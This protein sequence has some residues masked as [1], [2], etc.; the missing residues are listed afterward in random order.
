[1]S[2][3]KTSKRNAILAVL[4]TRGKL[5]A[6][7]ISL[8][9]ALMALP[10]V[11]IGAGLRRRRAWGRP[12]AAALAIAFAALVV[13]SGCY[14]YFR[15]W[16]LQTGPPGAGGGLL[17]FVKVFKTRP[18]DE[19]VLTPAMFRGLDNYLDAGDASREAPERI[20]RALKDKPLLVVRD[21]Q[22]E[23]RMGEPV[24]LVYSPRWNTFRGETSLELLAHDFRVGAV[25]DL[26]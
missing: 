4:E 11:E 3:E 23:L 7:I 19:L 22:A 8:S 9:T 26:A 6:T 1:M 21:R 15:Q 16:D 2:E 18:V 12:T 25:P 20:T 5:L 10:L 17:D 14:G 24:H 13:I